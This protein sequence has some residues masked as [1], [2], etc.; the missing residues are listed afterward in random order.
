MTI[1]RVGAV[2]P[3]KLRGAYDADN[4]AR[5]QILFSSL[6]AFAE[7]GLFEEIVVVTPPRDRAAAERLCADW[8]SLPLTVIDE[9]EYLP[10]LRRHWFVK[11]W[12]LQQLIKLNAANWIDA[13]FFLTLDPDVI[14]CKP[15]RK[16][17]LF[18]EGRALLEPY[19]RGSRP[20]WWTGSAR[21]LG[22]PADLSA[23]GMMV[24]PALLAR[25][26]CRRLFQQLEQRHGDHWATILLRLTRWDWTEYALYYLC[27]EQQ[28]MLP[29][30]HAVAGSG[31]PK[32][33]M[34]PSAVWS[35]FQFAG[36]NVE[37][38]FDPAA[39]GFFTLVQ[40]N[41]RIPPEAIR[42]RLAGHL[43]VR[44]GDDGRERGR[45]PKN[46]APSRI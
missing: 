29:E 46:G 28:G 22:A 10:S 36:W 18:V 4:L 35:K 15:L 1:E 42:Q 30:F 3:L 23:A 6:A 32:R 7:P 20:E 11:G 2:L 27:A 13:P 33:L 19:S 12:Y 26:I 25:A 24:T 5:C 8:R 40:S 43:E 41:T 17:D 16:A 31:A 39:A 38:C 21:V 14:L 44:S 37:E 45:E 9:R 34:C